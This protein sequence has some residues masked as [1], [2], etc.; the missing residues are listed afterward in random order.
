LGVYKALFARSP[1]S[2]FIHSVSP[3]FQKGRKRSAWL[4]G[5]LCFFL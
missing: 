1:S 4:S 3:F 5:L 2:F